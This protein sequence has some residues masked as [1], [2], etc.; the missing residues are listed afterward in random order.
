VEVDGE[1][2]HHVQEIVDCKLDR[3]RRQPLLYRVRWTGYHED[4]WEPAENINGL[5]AID[6]FHQ[7]YPNKSGPLPENPVDQQ[8][9]PELEP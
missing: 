9:L 6:L 5:E 3:R 1:I 2:E 7:R 4:T 8:V